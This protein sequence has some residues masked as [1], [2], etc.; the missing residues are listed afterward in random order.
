[1]TSHAAPD[2]LSGAVGTPYGEEVHVVGAKKGGEDLFELVDDKFVVVSIDVEY[3]ADLA[4]PTD[5][6]SSDRKVYVRFSIDPGNVQASTD[7]FI[8]SERC[9]KPV[10]MVLPMSL[11]TESAGAL[12]EMEVWEVRLGGVQQNLWGK[13]ENLFTSC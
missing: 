11:T 12:M 1:M 9:S 10:E 13:V 3:V 4:W 7:P 5:R 8:Y 6:A 2:S